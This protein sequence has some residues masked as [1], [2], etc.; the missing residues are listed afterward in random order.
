MSK[1]NS[2]SN[3]TQPPSRSSSISRS[4]NFMFTTPNDPDDNSLP[5]TRNS[6]RPPSAWGS[7][8]SSPSHE[9]NS[10]I[11]TWPYSS[12]NSSTSSVSS[13]ATGH[14]EKMSASGSRHTAF[15]MSAGNTSM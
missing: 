14:T 7:P 3:T 15:G 9:S 6:S 4:S 1:N 8:L 12:K 2:T 10:T 5:G 11:G 13:G